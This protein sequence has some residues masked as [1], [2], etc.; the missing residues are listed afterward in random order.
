VVSKNSL[1]ASCF[2]LIPVAAFSASAASAQ[3]TPAEGSG[4]QPPQ[5]DIV[6]TGSRT[7]LASD[8]S[9]TTGLPIAIEKVPQ[10]ISLVSGDFIKAANLKTIGQVADYTPGAVNAG[11]AEQI[12]SRIKLRGFAAGK[13]VDGL[14]LGENFNP[15]YA[16][17]E[18][19]EVV[20]GPA[21]VVYGTSFTGG[22][23]NRVT[24]GA[25][26]NT[27]SYISLQGGSYNEFRAEGQLA[28]PLDRD[29][30]LHALVVGVAQRGDD[31]KDV[32]KHH[33]YVVYIGLNADYGNVTGF[34]HGGYERHVRTSFDGI[35][36]KAD[37]SPA[38]VGRSFFIGTAKD[39]LT[40][41][42]LY[43]NANLT[44]HTSDSLEF[45]LKGQIEQN[46][47]RGAAPYASG[48]DNAGNATLGVQIY[49]PL[50]DMNYG[51]GLTSLWKLDH[52]GLR[53]SFVT[54]AA[55]YQGERIHNDQR[56]VTFPNGTDE[57]PVNLLAGEDA[58]A[59][60][61]NAAVPTPIISAH[62]TFTHTF[63][64][65]AQAVL[66]PIEQISILLGASYSKPSIADTNNGRSQ[67]FSPKGRMS[68]RAGL[69]WE[70]LPGANVY[71]S[72]SQSFQPQLR[73]DVNSNVLPPLVGEQYEVG[74]KYRT[75]GGKLLLTAA[76]FRIT[77][78]N[79][80][81]FDRP[82]NG[83]DRYKPIGEVTYKG[84]ELQAL[85]HVTRE[86][87]VNAGYAYLD[88][89]ITKSSNA[90][91]VGKTDLFL[92]KNTFSLYTT[93]SLQSGRLKGASIGGGVRY[94]SDQRTSLTGVTRPIPAYTVVDASIGYALEKWSFQL[95]IRNLG[96]KHY[97]INNYDSLFYGNTYG[98]PRSA[99][100]TISRTF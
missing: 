54:V 67:D 3:A 6:V 100:F 64:L 46:T 28:V 13:A 39:E 66:K 97:F 83:T 91:T 8:T 86:L 2:A 90:A 58:I 38:P 88:P 47:L 30:H 92:P 27:P 74:A 63:T 61:F 99:E 53:D 31:F 71:G 18:R 77:Q 37:G 98:V 23:V 85:G 68:Y 40:T 81:A 93:Y 22:L 50:R 7:F 5:G 43:A 95:N 87:Q 4:E 14:T 73:I 42:A 19:L 75:L 11:S 48:L 35:P 94:I 70:F 9:G 16:T 72:F 56:D 1:R 79:K 60:L 44:W 96:D 24:K 33:D 82:V 20:K 21:S 51:I 57:A 49:D 59:S 76:A 26:S 15:D 45:S 17:I 52:L 41:N 55:L 12:N 29:G 32:V 10:S 62:N 34:I 36:T 89:K 69:T 78:T 65:S 25:N 84:V 80:A